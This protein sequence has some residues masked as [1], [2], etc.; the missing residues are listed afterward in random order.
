MKRQLKETSIM[1]KRGPQRVITYGYNTQIN[2]L[3]VVRVVGPDKEFC[4][5]LSKSGLSIGVYFTGHARA[6]KFANKYLKG[7]DFTRDPNKITRDRKLRKCVYNAK[8]M[9]G[10]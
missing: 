5:V 6:I 2:G 4:I 10:L 1:G 8:I 7:F 3:D 9:E